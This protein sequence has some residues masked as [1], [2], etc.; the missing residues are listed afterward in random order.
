MLENIPEA[1][2]SDAETAPSPNAITWRSGAERNRKLRQWRRAMFMHYGQ[3]PRALRVAWVLADLFNIRDGY[4]FARNSHIAVQAVVTERNVQKTLTMLQKDGAILRR[5][6]T[7]KGQ[8]LRVIYPATA[9]VEHKLRHVP[10]ETPRATSPGR[11]VPRETPI[12]LRL[13]PLPPTT[14]RG[15]K[16]NVL[17]HARLDAERREHRSRAA[18]ANGI[19]TD[20]TD[21]EENA[22]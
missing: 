10:R 13:N 20:N 2:G 15:R 22:S 17:D 14:R 7:V 16:L 5:T 21:S 6:I 19:Y 3:Q 18:N 1:N 4:A 12:N 9:I 8:R 11:H